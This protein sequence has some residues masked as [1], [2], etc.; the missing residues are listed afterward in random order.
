MLCGDAQAFA[1][2][3]HHARAIAG[4]RHASKEIER[5]DSRDLSLTH[6]GSANNCALIPFDPDMLIRIAVCHKLTNFFPH[7]ASVIGS[8]VTLL[9]G[10]KFCQAAYI[11]D[12]TMQ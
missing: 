12:G 7:V 4:A 3:D 9:R 5:P 10:M 8:C 11:G 1:L 2:P 6:P